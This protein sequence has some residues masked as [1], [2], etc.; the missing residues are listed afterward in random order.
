MRTTPTILLAVA[1]LAPSIN[2]AQSPSCPALFSGLLAPGATGD[3]VQ[4]SSDSAAARAELIGADSNCAGLLGMGLGAGGTSGIGNGQTMA[5]MA[6]MAGMDSAQMAQIQ[7]MMAGV[8]GLSS[9]A[10]AGAPPGIN[11]GGGAGLSVPGKSRMSGE[12]EE[13]PI[14][15]SSDLARDLKQG[16]TLVR[17]IDW[18]AGAG[19]VAPEG[20][21]SFDRAMAQLAAAMSQVGGSYQLDLYMD[22]ESPKVV[23]RTLGPQRLATIQSS[24]AKRGVTP[25]LGEIRKDGDPRVEIVRLK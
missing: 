24:L 25:R 17:N 10:V 7:A 3:S 9:G 22:Q 20:A 23:V 18:E 5:A 6:A 13:N 16:K 8:S 12:E 1:L 4:R 21:A 11:L 2:Q 15:L 19:A 14:G